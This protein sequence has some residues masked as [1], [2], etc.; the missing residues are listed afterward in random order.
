MAHDRCCTAP[1]FEFSC[2]DPNHAVLISI[3]QCHDACHLPHIVYSPT[4]M[5]QDEDLPLKQVA[6]AATTPQRNHMQQTQA[7][8]GVSLQ[9]D[10]PDVKEHEQAGGGSSLMEA[11]VYAAENQAAAA[12]SDA[13]AG[14]SSVSGLSGMSD[15][16]AT[17]G[18]DQAGLATGGDVSTADKQVIHYTR[19]IAHAVYL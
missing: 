9:A 7:P 8:V 12:Q 1:L 3:V 18:E 14:A 19:C 15:A 4:W 10:T 16:G 11:A 6:L 2:I 17:A 5:L 13:V